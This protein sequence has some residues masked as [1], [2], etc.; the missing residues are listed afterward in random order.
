M[1]R[2]GSIAGLVFAALTSLLVMAVV[3]AQTSRS[4]WAF[5]VE[6]TSGAGAPGV[7]DFTLPLEVMD[8][9]RE[10]LADLRLYD[11][12]GKEIPYAIRIRREVGDRLEVGGTQFNQATV[13]TTAS[14]VSLDLGED[15]GEHNEVDIDT[16]GSN[17]RRRVTVE[18]SDTGTEWKVLQTGA[19][20]FG[21]ESQNKTVQ[22]NR[23]TYPPSRYRYLRIRVF[24][25][26]LTDKG[27]PTISNVNAVKEIRAKGE[28]TTWNVNLP[29]Y[30]LL[31]NQGAPS[32]AWNIDLG[33]RVPCDRL[34]V[35]VDD[36]SFS[37]PFQIE[38]GEDPQ[39]M[40]L[41]A[42]GELTRRVGE[43]PAPPIVI[44]FEQEEY[45][46]KLRLLLKDYSNQ[47]LNITGIKAGAPARQL[48]FELKEPPALP[49]RLYFG[50]RNATAPH[51][52]FEKE[53]P[54]KLLSA[55][56]R[57]GVGQIA[58]NPE[59]KPEPLPLTERVPWLIYIVLAVSS[60][61]LGLILFN[62]AR[63]TVASEHGKD[64][65]APVSDL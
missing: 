36:A 57:V 63:S 59:Y 40:R 45:V 49:L 7:Y 32:S 31:R 61:A 28:L 30:Q 38:A 22:S 50:N 21:F 53:I 58:N 62:L 42:S 46:R 54:A 35:E 34:I 55:P 64:S 13:G 51:Y 18:G 48:V 8:K 23:V 5:L 60:L 12:N 14:E 44:H 20:I 27:P 9:A 4:S 47:T 2:L 16:S 37:R 52:D 10:D 17:F 43:Q 65:S 39:A 24:A 19:L 15:P 33:V 25:D 3:V 56:V 11:A 29:S 6:V 26:E 41:V 1:K